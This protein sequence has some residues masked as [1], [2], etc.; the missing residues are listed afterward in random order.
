MK[1]YVKNEELNK[2]LATA[3]K[4]IGK[5]LAAAGLKAMF[6]TSENDDADE[7]FSALVKILKEYVE[8]TKN[9]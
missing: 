6:V 8:I 1:T 7:F 5:V 3:D 9:A 2:I 4:D